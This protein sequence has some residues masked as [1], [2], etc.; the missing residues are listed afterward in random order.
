[1]DMLLG[2]RVLTAEEAVQYGLVSRLVE[3]GEALGAA[4]TLAAQIAEFGPLAVRAVKRSAYGA[5]GLTEAAALAQELEI[6]QPVFASKDAREGPR[7]F[8]EKRK[9]AFE[10]R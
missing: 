8:A 1:M 10:G 3:K 6:G 9:P 4:K 5:D 7:A 2:G